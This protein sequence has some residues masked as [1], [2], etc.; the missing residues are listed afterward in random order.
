MAEP[1]LKK[2]TKSAQD[3]SNP[4]EPNTDDNI[5]I[6][7]SKELLMEL[8][9][10]AYHGMFDEDVV[11]HIA[12]VLELLGL[13]KIP[14][15]DSH[16]LRMKVFPLSLADDARQWW[17]NEGEGK[18]TTWEELVEKLFCKFYPESH[19]GEDK[20]L[21]EGDNWGIDPLEFI[22]Q[23]NSSFENHMKMDERIKKVWFHSWMNG[24]HDEHDIE[25][26][27][28]LRQMKRKKDNKNDELPN[29]RVCKAEK[30]KAIKYS[31]GPNEEYIA[32]RRCEYNAWERNEDSMSQIYQEIFQKKDEGW[33]VTQME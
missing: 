11:D 15:V 7:L 21:D 4:T 9:N 17:I 30:F 25:K 12:K 14:S 32:I 1:I 6:E 19:N 22:S 2:Y 18:I 5:N 3:E 26:G 8:K 29:K 28:E 24:T 23:V 31:L 33:K 10:N 20:I 13:I 27:N 16:Q